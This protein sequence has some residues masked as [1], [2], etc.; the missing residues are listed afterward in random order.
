MRNTRNT[1]RASRVGIAITMATVISVAAGAHLVSAE[2]VVKVNAV[3][4]KVEVVFVLDTTGSM[5]SLIASAKE[6]I[7]S[8]ANTLAQAKPPP[9][10][11]FGLIGYRDKGDAYVTKFTE[12]TTDL[13][14]LY[15]NLMA[16]QAGGGGD[17][18]ESVNQALHEAISDIEWSAEEGAYRVVFL[19]G[20]C[21]PHMDY[22]EV[23]YPETCNIAIQKDVAI[24]T[25]LCGANQATAKV[26][27]EIAKSTHGEF[28][29]V[30][31]GG[32]AVTIAAPQDKKIAELSSDLDSTR[33]FYGKKKE[34]EAHAKRE[35]VARKINSKSSVSA[36]AQRASFN[37]SDAGVGNFVP[38]KELIKDYS[39]KIA[40]LKNVDREELPKDLQKMSIEELEKHVAENAFKRK[41]IQHQI[42]KLSQE[43]QNF[44]KKELA[45]TKGVAE[46]SLEYNVFLSIKKQ[47]K[48]RS[49]S[50]DD[51]KV[52]Y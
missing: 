34:L 4:P 7:W 2:S 38:G 44:I 31:Q 33:I 52:T 13:D 50:Y 15:L 8:I 25:I 23:K 49:A 28:F 14:D 5:S 18:P 27:K 21:P 1:S 45:K 19:V 32:N 10:I 29:V 41:N 6:K 11:K 35:N 40:D 17:S 39:D 12:M 26:W 22:D 47:T 16:F 24:N 51:A 48:G 20:D 46:A 37:A 43:R 42:Q 36:K 30:E 3:R 9:E